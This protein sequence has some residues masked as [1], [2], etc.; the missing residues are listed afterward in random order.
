MSVVV[1]ESLSLIHQE[2][3][4][5]LAEARS[6]LENYIDSDGGAADLGVCANALHSA[7]GALQIAEANGASLLAEEMEL[8]CRML[9]DNQQ[10]APTDQGIEAL[11]RAIV[12]LPAYVETIMVGGRDIPL[13]LLP[14]LNDL[15]A[16]RSKPLLSEST[17]L[18]LDTG[19]SR[20]EVA[21]LIAPAPNGQDIK[22]LAKSLRTR[23]QL[24]LLGWIKG[25]AS[26]N[27]LESMHQVAGALEQAASVPEV[28]Q[29]WWVVGGVI[30]A[31]R[32]GGLDT[33]VAIKRLMGQA[34]REIKRL[35]SQGERVYT[36]EPPTELLNNLL[37]YVAR[38][39]TQSGR[40]SKIREA[41][42]LIDLIPGDDQV[43]QLR[44]MLAA[45]SA[46]LMRTVADA[47]RQDLTNAKDVLD[48]YARTGME[49]VAE[50]EPQVEMLRKI[51]DTL[52]VLGLARLR[53]AVA[54]HSDEL[55]NI[56]QAGE[57]P[58]ESRLIVLAAALLRVEDAL[59]A[60]LIALVESPPTG[61]EAE[62]EV[63]IDSDYQQVTQAVMR[64]C[65]VNIARIKDAISGVMGQ[66]D[67]RADINELESLLSGVNAGLAMLGKD[68]A[69]ATLD[70]AGEHIIGFV[71]QG[72]GHLPLENL[73]RLADAIV[74]LEYY[75]ETIQ[76]GRKEPMYMLD[77]ADRCLEAMAEAA[78]TT[79][80]PDINVGS[81]EATMKIEVGDL[82]AAGGDKTEVLL[83]PSI[84]RTEVL[85]APEDIAAAFNRPNVQTPTM[86]AG[87]ETQFIQDMSS[88]ERTAIAKSVDLPEFMVLRAGDDAPDPE[89]L[90]IFLEEAKECVEAIQREF[91]RWQADTKAHEPLATVR[92]SY[93]TLKGSGR[94]V[95]AELIGEYAWSVENLL[96]R[97]I[98]NTLEPA[99]EVVE[100]LRQSVATTPEL[101][102]QLEVGVAASA[103]VAI[104]IAN[105]HGYADQG[106]SYIPQP[107]AQNLRELESLGDM[108]A[109]D[110]LLPEEPPEP[111][112]TVA[113]MDPVLLDILRKESA[114]HLS[115]LR[116]YVAESRASAPPF[117][118]NKDVYRAAHT[119]QGSLMMAE[120]IPA[121]PL[122]EALNQLVQHADE[123][124]SLLGSDAIDAISAAT[125]TL[126]QVIGGLDQPDSGG[127]AEVTAVVERLYALRSALPLLTGGYSEGAAEADE[128]A[129]AEH[130]ALSI[131]AQEPEAP[132]IAFDPEIAE[133]FA[134][135]AAEI[136]DSADGSLSRLSGN[137]ADRAPLA[138]LQRDLHTLK[139]GARM[140]GIRPMGDF[141]H[142]IE[143]FIGLCADGSRPMT[144]EIVGFLQ[145]SFDELNRMREEVSAGR[146]VQP[147][148]LLASRLQELIAGSEPMAAIAE[149]YFD[150]LKVD[151]PAAT[152]ALVPAEP[153]PQPEPAIEPESEPESA[154]VPEP[155]EPVAERPRRD[156][157]DR[158]GA[159]ARDLKAPAVP[160]ET[161]IVSALGISAAPNLAELLSSDTPE[162]AAELAA[163]ADSADE[164]GAEESPAVVETGE[165]STEPALRESAAA[166]KDFV[167][168]DSAALEEMLN[169][170]GEIS[171]FHSRLNQQ[172]GS[173]QFNLEELGGT[174]TRLR[175]QLRAMDIETEAQILNRYK[176]QTADDE[177]FDPL[178]MDRF[179][180][181]QQ[182]S[183][184][185]AESSSDVSS[186]K[187]LLQNLARETESLLVQEARTV[188]ELQDNLMRTRMVPFQQH[189]PRLA[190]L[191][192]Q[193]ASDENKKVDFVVEGGTGELDRQ[194]LEKMLPP[195]EHMLRNAVVHG[196]ESPEERLRVNK[197]ETGQIRISLRRDGSE[198][199][200]EVSD[201]GA[202]LNVDEIRNRASRQADLSDTQVISDEAA[203]RLILKAGVS[204]AKQLTQSAGRGVGMDVVVNE[205]AK[206]GGTLGINSQPGSGCTFTIRLPYTLAVAQ[207]LI[208]RLANE[209]YALPMPSIGGVIRISRAEFD[210][211]LTKPTPAIEYG[212]VIYTFRHLGQYLG[213]K[214]LSM[215]QDTESVSLILVK[216]EEEAVALITDKTVDSREI[217][218][219]PLGAQ[220]ATVRGVS[221]ATIL[222]DGRIVIILDVAV[223]VRSMPM[224]DNITRLVSEGVSGRIPLAMVVDDS[225]TMRRVSQRLLER[226][227]LRVVTA[228]D[229]LDALEKLEDE[230]PDIVLLDIE[231]PRMDGYEFAKNLRNN[232]DTS[233]VPIIMITSRSGEKHRARAI[234]LGVNDYL[235]KPYQEQ[236]MLES[237]RSLLADKAPPSL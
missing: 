77:N 140:A 227:G 34:D 121:I 190:R 142:E 180:A 57:A 48:I 2:L 108:L 86:D 56:V 217:V 73:N 97:I 35:A 152:E 67:D 194:V 214:D 148:A 145:R 69:L 191:V 207:S 36:A 110:L 91:P 123:H 74:S 62:F 146:V 186:I 27:E 168:V 84:D 122:A 229:G 8:T 205:V 30:D 47:I 158:L 83:V 208:V 24:G 54:A 29:L 135:E 85:K 219:K 119:L 45:P 20:E 185:L 107:L 223:L 112:A 226:G 216:T 71:R 4:I 9:V 99:A 22:A 41:Y 53:E 70:K 197:P 126:Q 177:E 170:A 150:D 231:M 37:Y 215:P 13:V 175:E 23:F 42:N 18:L 104:L 200:I 189:V 118:V 72:A 106:R 212:G 125:D 25:G 192:R 1:T 138:E 95:G 236:E 160:S 130:D 75:L 173:I 3:L 96:N 225:I 101:I 129:A 201:D 19:V 183:R 218:V 6:I 228:N 92:R 98:N 116:D 55:R 79:A 5:T 182:L 136:L 233:K 90:E 172:L 196:I 33:S 114:T 181:I 210:D 93:H 171:I 115:T 44:Q 124:N 59:D 141:S 193:T 111:E 237:V 38:A 109:P 202:G 178:E 32:D 234:E 102:E 167:R 68:R 81:H 17:L 15:R 65:V 157:D 224:G 211:C 10:S 144:A 137:S 58:E 61:D 94:M 166:S 176:T 128:L 203:M 49:N 127:P 204:T 213:M 184:A 64:E 60:E 50:L 14:L 159:L 153:G 232:P 117:A 11:T 235:G 120:A 179:S 155:E 161:D 131:Q 89:L 134:E 63:E 209:T 31:L 51:S 40:V 139:G 221:G 174:V 21:A 76:N 46:N 220:L 164:P 198:V 165:V 66:T 199:M 103:N 105:A 39:T 7:R 195:F 151:M 222:G 163:D 143:D 28:H 78:L 162:P 132:S 188:A 43:E 113:S 147:D 88:R 26:G 187:D 16:A 82:P 52:G 100:L 156:F 206:L 12:Q 169:S 230:I 80:A 154:V 149:V 133:I 87:V